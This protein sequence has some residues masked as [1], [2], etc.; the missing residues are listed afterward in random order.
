MDID[1]PERVALLVIGGCK[2]QPQT[3]PMMKA[4]RLVTANQGSRVPASP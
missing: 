1:D 4:S 2:S 3:V